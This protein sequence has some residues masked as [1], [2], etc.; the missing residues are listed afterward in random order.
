M[1]LAPHATTKQFSGDVGVRAKEIKK[2]HEDVRLKIEKQ[3][4]K[5]VEQANKRKKFV[6]FEVGDLVWIH[7]R[8]DRFPSSK[9]GK[10]KQ[11]VDGPF[12]IIEKIG[13]NA[14]KLLLPDDYDISP[15]LNVKDLRSYHDEDLRASLFSEL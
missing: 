11:R 6:E 2:L 15:I 1:D 13:D 12:K 10:L 7:L 8:K 14:Y 5:Y 4:A 9:F 3:N